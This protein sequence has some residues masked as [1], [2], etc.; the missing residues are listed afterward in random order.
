MDTI[1]MSETNS[2][3]GLN[4]NVNCLFRHTI[5]KGGNSILNCTFAKAPVDFS[6]SN[7]ELSNTEVLVVTN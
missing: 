5:A 7:T 1:T 4:C 6:C 2:L 3:S